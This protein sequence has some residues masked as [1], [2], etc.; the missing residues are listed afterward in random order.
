MIGFLKTRGP[1]RKET[2][3]DRTKAVNMALMNNKLKVIEK[4]NHGY[5]GIVPREDH[6]GRECY[7]YYFTC[8]EDFSEIEYVHIYDHGEGCEEDVLEIRDEWKLAIIG[9]C[10]LFK[11][12]IHIS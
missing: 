4:N 5:F 12:E 8:S 10:I 2:G 11:M 6:F 1:V 3:I 7:D 9:K